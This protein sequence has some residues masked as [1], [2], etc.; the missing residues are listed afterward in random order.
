MEKTRIAKID[1]NGSL[2]I[3]RR[4]V[5]T[6]SKCRTMG[7]DGGE[8]TPCA[9]DC[10]L[11]NEYFPEDEGRK[12]HYVNIQCSHHRLCYEIVEDNRSRS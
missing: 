5:W 12:F 8:S 10:P 9:D 7:L 11:F 1:H 3:R 6:T 2:I 4:G